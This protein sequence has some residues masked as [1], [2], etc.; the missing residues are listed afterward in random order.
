[1]RQIQLFPRFA[2]PVMTGTMK[3]HICQARVS[4]GDLVELK[5]GRLLLGRAQIRMTHDVSIKYQ[6]YFPSVRL[7]GDQLDSKGMEA[8]ARRVGFPDLATLIDFHAEFDLLPLR[9]KVLDFELVREAVI[10]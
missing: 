3:Q 10:A 9:S 5:C 4:A 8:F 2:A 1:M 6:G 7:N